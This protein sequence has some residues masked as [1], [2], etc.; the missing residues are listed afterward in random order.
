MNTLLVAVFDR[1][2]SSS[3]SVLPLGLFVLLVS[4]FLRPLSASAKAWLW[5]LVSFKLLFDLVL[6]PAP[7]LEDGVSGLDFWARASV[8]VLPW[9]LVVLFFLIKEIRGGVQLR[10]MTDQATPMMATELGATSRVLGATMG[11]NVPPKV[12]ESEYVTA[13]MVL[14]VISPTVLL[15]AGISGNLSNAELEMALAHEIAHVQR[16]DLV[17]AI[18]PFVAQCLFFF[19]PFAWLARREWATERE[20]ACDATALGATDGDSTS[21]AALLLKIV[22]LDHRGGLSPALGATA[23]YQALR[24]RINTMKSP[25]RQRALPSK[26]TAICAFT[27]ALLLILPWTLFAK[28]KPL[29][30]P[31]D[32][33]S[34]SLLA[35]AGF[36]Q[37]DTFP[38][39][40]TKSSLLGDAEAMGVKV[41]IDHQV[42]HS[43]KAS[44]RFD[45]T[46]QRFNPVLIVN[47]EIPFDKTQTKLQVGMWVKAERA[48]KATMA[49]WFLKD[50]ADGKIDWGSYIGRGTKFAD[51]DWKQ[52]GSVLAIP[53]G[54]DKI[55]ISLQM[56]GPGTVWMDDVDVKYVPDSTPL[57]AAIDP[58][59]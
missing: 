18:V 9:I 5:W 17:Y 55:V 28:S 49:V 26:V 46:T 29:G 35:N 58:N 15:P 37:G 1:L 53:P 51:H 42:Y 38:T 22:A 54:T 48:Y 3:V 2:I 24:K 21:Y 30:P 27:V 33:G 14:G 44:L 19:H 11:L 6:P 23:D 20:S 39:G 25:N 36:E 32:P 56:Y 59:E 34:S 31:A 7:V 41:S 8:A 4:L 12:C 10:R 16:N 43:G 45:R 47:Q 40:W 52:Y 50:G 57:K 13:P